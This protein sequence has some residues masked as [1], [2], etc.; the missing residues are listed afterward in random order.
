MIGVIKLSHPDFPHEKAYLE[1]VISYL[2]ETLPEIEEQKNEVDA[3]VEYGLKH[4]NPDNP[5]Q[6]I[7]FNLSVSLQ[8]DLS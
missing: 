4:Y 5:E 6:F 7:A 8:N 1:N 3:H 2:Q